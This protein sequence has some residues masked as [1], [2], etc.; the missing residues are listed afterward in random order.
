MQ[1][2]YACSP[3]VQ[4][5][6]RRLSTEVAGVPPTLSEQRLDA[7]GVDGESVWM[8]QSTTPQ[9]DCVGLV[10]PTAERMDTI[11][12]LSRDAGARPL[13]LVNP[14][15][16]VRTHTGGLRRHHQSKVGCAT[17]SQLSYRLRRLHRSATTL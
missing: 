12:T 13:L 3:V 2:Y 11:R 5:L 10:Q 4:Q 16:K 14:Q 15:W 9:D 1:L 8:A 7:S 6:L 17:T